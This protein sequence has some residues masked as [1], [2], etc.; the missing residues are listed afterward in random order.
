MREGL[1]GVKVPRLKR[2]F[3]SKDSLGQLIHKQHHDVAEIRIIR[4]L[5]VDGLILP[6]GG[7]ISFIAPHANFIG[8]FGGPDRLVVLGG[9]TPATPH[10]RPGATNGIGRTQ[11]AQDDREPA[12][13]GTVLGSVSRASCAQIPFS[14][15]GESRVAGDS[16]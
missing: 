14:R 6:A 5:A 13:A 4:V 15:Q 12:F 10:P 11:A 16:T 1:E 9:L 3:D 8:R 2:C 7:G